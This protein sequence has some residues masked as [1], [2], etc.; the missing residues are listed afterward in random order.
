MD[1]HSALDVIAVRAIETQD[2]ARAV[3]SDAERSWASRAAAEVV[4]EKAAADAFVAQR[5]ALVVERLDERNRALLAAARGM[6]WQAWQ[7]WLFVFVAF[8]LGFMIDRMASSNRVDLLAPPVLALLVWNVAVY[9]ALLISR[10]F[11]AGK[12][13]EPGLL[14]KLALRL[15]GLVP[16]RSTWRPDAQGPD[17]AVALA[18]NAMIVKAWLALSMPLHA[19]RIGRILHAAAAALA[20]GVI[21]GLY[22]R[23]LALEFRATWESTFLD[24]QAVHAMLAI[25]LAPGAWLTGIA[26]PD[27][28]HLQSIQAPASENAAVWLHLL[29]AS[30]L[31]VVLLP[32]SALAA[33]AAYREWQLARQFPLALDE[34]Y[35]QH[36]LR[37]FR[38]GPVRVRVVPFSYTLPAAAQTGLETIVARAFGGSAALMIEP[39]LHWDDDA[40]ALRRIAASGEGPIIA[41]FNLTATPEEE[42]HGPLVEAFKAYFHAEHA[43]I[44]V[45]DASGFLARWPDEKSRLARRR[46]AWD[47]LLAAH[48]LPVVHANLAAPD[49][50]EIDATFDA[51]FVS[52]QKETT[53]NS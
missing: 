3:W 52:Q 31:L 42:V 20:L 36:L 13:T 28:A 15:L 7:G 40:G 43:L 29:A 53:V 34:P 51:A 14:R 11:R 39:P 17:A 12:S 41:L 23:G 35:F 45:V 6:H 38:G 47:E 37:G 1:E 4:G 16:W 24:A 19:A 8:V 33:R 22:A 25:I 49:L 26:L 46:Q 18:S 30:V 5:A 27:A 2:R 32:R 21:A 48:R 50:P 10:L 9:L 44:A